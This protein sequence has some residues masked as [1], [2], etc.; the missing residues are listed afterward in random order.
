MD[1]WQSHGMLCVDDFA[2]TTNCVPPPHITVHRY[3]CCLFRSVDVEILSQSHEHLKFVS[4]PD[5]YLHPSQEK[6]T[7]WE[8]KKKIEHFI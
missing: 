3:F 5:R 6:G 7:G 4:T 8:P 2:A 1:F